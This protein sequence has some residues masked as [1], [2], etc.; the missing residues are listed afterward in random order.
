[1]KALL[2]GMTF[3]R[4]PVLMMWLGAVACAPD[5]P[6]SGPVEH[7]LPPELQGVHVGSSVLEL[8]QVAPGVSFT[9]YD[10]LGLKLSGDPSGFRAAWFSTG[11]PFAEMLPEPDA[12]IREIRL[13]G[14]S[15]GADAVARVSRA[16][17]GKA[18]GVR[19]VRNRSVEIHVWEDGAT[20][21]GAELALPL[22]GSGKAELRLFAGRWPGDGLPGF[23]PTPCATR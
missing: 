10:G 12:E 6:G 4:V 23:G 1:M 8:Q 22:Y 15:V 11:E 18:A 21:T 14:D 2:H 20:R 19:C 5:Q 16:F 3:R 9:P 17:A 7:L 13:E